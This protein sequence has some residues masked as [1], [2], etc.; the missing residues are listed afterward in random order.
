M[1]KLNKT[2]REMIKIFQPMI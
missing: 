1:I 2:S